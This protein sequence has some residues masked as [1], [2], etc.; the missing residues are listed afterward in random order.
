MRKSFALMLL[1]SL[2]VAL[3]AMG[4]AQQQDTATESTTEMP[5]TEMPA[6]TSMLADTTA[7]PDTMPH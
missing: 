6:D 4:C 1:L 2:T 7:M 5:A 3:A